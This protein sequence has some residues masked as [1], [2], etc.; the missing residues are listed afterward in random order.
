MRAGSTALGAL[1]TLTK[2]PARDRMARSLLPASRSGVLRRG[3]VTGAAVGAVR[4]LTK[5]SG[6]DRVARSLSSAEHSSML[7]SGA[8]AG[9]AL[10]AVSAA[11]AA[12]TAIRRRVESR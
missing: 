6:R 10:V 11:S 4:S 8:A 2:D 12:T 5:D 3:V 7:R 1:R 9:V